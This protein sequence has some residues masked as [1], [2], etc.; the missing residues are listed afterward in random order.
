V[1]DQ[2]SS[3]GCELVTL[4]GGEPTLK[5]GWATIAAAAVEA[6]MYCNMVTNGVYQ[7]D[8]FRA[9][10]V[11]QALEAGMCNVGISIDG[12][13]AVHDR[14]RGPGNYAR[15]LQSVRDFTEAGMPVAVLTT[16]NRLNLDRLDEV[17]LRVVDAGATQWRLQLAKPMGNLADHDDLVISPIDILTLL[18]EL[19]R[20]K[21]LPGVSLQVGDSIGY[22]G[23]PDRVLRSRGWRGKREAWR[24][25]QAGMRAIG[26]EA[27]GNIKGC[28][29]MQARYDGE[30]SFVEGNLNNSSLAEIWNKPGAFAYNREFQREQLTGFC[31]S[32]RY[33]ERC[34]GG[35]TCVAAATEGHLGEDKY[36]FYRMSVLR[37]RR[38]LR[39]APPASLAA[40]A[41]V[42]A[43]SGS[44]C[45]EPVE[46][47][48]NGTAVVD[49]GSGDRLDPTFPTQ[50]T[51]ASSDLVSDMAR[52]LVGDP[53]EDLPIDQATDSP[54]ADVAQDTQ[55]D[56]LPP[57]DTQPDDEMP[58][59][60]PDL[61][62]ADGSDDSVSDPDEMLDSDESLDSDLRQDR[63][64][65]VDGTDAGDVIDCEE[66]CCMCEY[67]VIPDPVY[68]ACCAIDP[69][70]DVCCE[71]DYGVP[72]PPECCE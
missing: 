55:P 17:R 59:S 26:I 57:E 25:C 47:T 6:G 9:E 68:E 41:F 23:A 42:L 58:S 31:R 30:D 49:S 35:A 71:C 32:C 69:C 13:P 38:R 11:S 2:L 53:V 66:V 33:A 7:N 21:R 28:L 50:D 67:G 48:E 44:A 12:P 34:R 54:P 27:N 65:L 60:D 72:P 18:P 20:M 36:C 56:N 29:S 51:R 39:L 22:Y 37:G 63:Q 70:E 14:I 43:L 4:S 46:T 62:L 64:D 15:A 5:R 52:D 24:G 19:A 10:V 8:S 45:D 1:V 16:V 61:D 40:S 3:L